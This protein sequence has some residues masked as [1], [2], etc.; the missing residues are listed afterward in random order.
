MVT[1]GLEFES[2]STV[3]II[4]AEQKPKFP[5]FRAHE[6]SY[7]LMSQVSG[8]SGR[9]QKRGKVII[10]TQQP[11]HW[12]ILDVVNHNYEAFFDRDLFERQKFSYPP[13]TR[14]I[15]ITLKHKDNEYLNAASFELADALRAN[16]GKR[17][18]GPHQ[19]LIARI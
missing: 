3:G 12:V 5:E 18:I 19:P 6:R 11:A 15:E 7:Q 16:L 8:R 10:Q 4:K 17:I 14:L 2:V 13:Y 1:K 9:K